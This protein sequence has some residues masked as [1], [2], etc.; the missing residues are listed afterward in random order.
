MREVY[1]PC[2]LLGSMA[3]FARRNYHPSIHTVSL[4]SEYKQDVFLI[5]HSPPL[6][7][8]WRDQ[9]GEVAEGTMWE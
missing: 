3:Q 5:S 8:W 6:V 7:C 1:T 9:V 4:Q 2:E